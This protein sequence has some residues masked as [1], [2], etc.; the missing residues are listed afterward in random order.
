MSKIIK[1]L[2]KVASRLSE[3][4]FLTNKGFNFFGFE[5]NTMEDLDRNISEVYGRVCAMMG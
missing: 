2:N 4:A 5:N 1:D 3:D